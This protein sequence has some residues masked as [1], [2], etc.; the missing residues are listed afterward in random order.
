MN[1]PVAPSAVAGDL[2]PADA[3]ITEQAKGRLH[4]CRY[5][6]WRAVSCVCRGGV[7]TLNGRLPSYYLKQMAQEAVAGIPGVRHIDNRIEVVALPPP[8]W[9][10][11]P[12]PAG[13]STA[14]PPQGGAA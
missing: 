2:R 3:R 13:H 7:L 14:P 12:G 5:G 6:V 10:S 8:A 9:A 1:A 4:D 11:R